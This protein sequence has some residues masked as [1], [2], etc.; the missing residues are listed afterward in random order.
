M[1]GRNG[2]RS[3]Q[4]GP[5]AG[6]EAIVREIHPPDVGGQTFV[7]EDRDGE[8]WRVECL[9][10][11]VE[12]GAR[13]LFMPLA[14]EAEKRGEM[15]RLVAGARSSWVCILRR[16]PAGLRL[17]PFGGLEAPELSLSEKD[18][19]GADDGTRVVVVPLE[20]SRK[21]ARKQ[22]RSERGRGRLA[23]GPRSWR[24]WRLLTVERLR[25][26]TVRRAGWCW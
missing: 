19:K 22:P 15:V 14:P 12:V 2:S 1:K 9:G 26:R 5:N 17:T 7:A 8:R 25:A 13:I 20:K 18:S 23:R 11:P 4:P 3:L 16:G 6:R 21:P 10:E 24:R